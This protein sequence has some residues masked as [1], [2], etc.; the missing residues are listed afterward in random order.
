ML[1]TTGDAAVA[2]VLAAAGYPETPRKGDVD[3]GAGRSG[4]SRGHGLPRRHGRGTPTAAIA[5]TAAAFWRWSGW[6]PRSPAAAPPPRRPPTRSPGQGM[7]RRH[8]IAAVLPPRGAVQAA[9]SPAPSPRRPGPPGRG[10]P[11]HDPAL[12]TARDG[13]DLDRPG[14]LRGDAPGRDR[15][16]PRRGRAAAWFRPRPS[17]RSR[18][19]PASTSTASPRSRRRPTTTSSPSSARSPR[20]SGRRA[21][22]CTSA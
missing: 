1:P 20:R 5:P 6:A 14:P 2:V 17:G 4:A 12:H 11:P 18:P 19:A 10:G 7:Q 21:A 3:L 9:A 8:D 16:R 15:R 22:T 13:R